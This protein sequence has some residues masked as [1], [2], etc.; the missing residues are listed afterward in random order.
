M[1]RLVIHLCVALLT[2]ALGT[3]SSLLLRGGLSSSNETAGGQ[4]TAARA[5]S[6][7]APAIESDLIS[8]LCDCA[9]GEM[10]FVPPVTGKPKAPING[11]ILNGRAISLPK[12]TNP[13]IANA[14]R[15]TGTVAV[16]VV[17]DER[18]CVQTARAISGHPLLRSAAVHAARQ[19]C[20]APTRLSGQPVKVK[21]VIRY[22]FV[23]E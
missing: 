1:Q 23:F 11:G 18:G 7:T 3:I 5:K 8:D 16:Q 19:A 4:R 12:P 15:A 6:S 14:A 2:F 13:P 22:K 10:E 21:G 9:S 17:I 20:F